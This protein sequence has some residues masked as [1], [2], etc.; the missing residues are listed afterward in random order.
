MRRVIIGAAV[1][2][3]SA[4]THAGQPTGLGLKAA[5]AAA[6]AF[7]D[8][9]ERVKL[10]LQQFARDFH[11]ANLSKD[12]A[13][14]DRLLAE[15]FVWVH[16]FGYADDKA[17]V[18]AEAL[19]D[20]A[21]PTLRVP[22]F[23]PPNQI[24]VS[25]DLAVTITPNGGTATG[26]RAWGTSVYI[27]RDGRWQLLQR[28]GTEMNPPPSKVPVAPDVLKSY[29]GRYTAAQRSVDI[30][31][32]ADGLYSVSE[33]FPPRLMMPTGPDQ[34]TTKVGGEIRFER[35]AEGRPIRVTFI[36]RGPPLTYQRQD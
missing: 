12:R 24:Y 13:A 9:V 21:R 11:A 28:Q 26:S 27:R 36:G 32:R 4:C 29:V 20:P 7:Q 25:G 10:E 6:A 30:Q 17:T 31:L 23:K 33:R 22:D 14:L 2:T 5:P 34:F 18:I 8:P 15:E 19:E 35:D 16:A 1:V 3:A